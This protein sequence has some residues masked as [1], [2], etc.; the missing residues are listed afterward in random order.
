MLEAV[1][2]EVKGSAVASEGEGSADEGDHNQPAEAVHH[3]HVILFLR[4]EEAVPLWGQ[5]WP[6]VLACHGDR[7]C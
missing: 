1:A 5:I 6:E 4:E 2:V 7:E 3:Y